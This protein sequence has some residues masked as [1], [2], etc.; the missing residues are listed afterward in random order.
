MRR[1]ASSGSKLRI[2]TC[3]APLKKPLNTEYTAAPCM[4]GAGSR[5]AM[6]WELAATASARSA[7]LVK[8]APPWFPPPSA[9]M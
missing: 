3:F 2:R 1:S 4:S 5:N 7:V 6:G 8:A 9:A